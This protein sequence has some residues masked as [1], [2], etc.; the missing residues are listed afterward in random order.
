MLTD[1]NI[2]EQFPRYFNFKIVKVALS[3]VGGIHGRGETR[4]GFQERVLG[5]GLRRGFL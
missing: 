5:E 3:P 2:D 4:M 1:L